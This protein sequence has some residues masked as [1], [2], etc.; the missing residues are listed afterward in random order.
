MDLNLNRLAVSA[1]AVFAALECAALTVTKV[2]EAPRINKS[3][4]KQIS[5]ITWAGDDLYYAV[6]DQNGRLYTLNLGIDLS[7]GAISATNIT[8][9]ASAK[10]EGAT[11]L[12]DCAFDKAAGSVWVVD[13]NGSKIYEVNPKTGKKNRTVKVPRNMTENYH[14]YGL[15]SLAMSSDGLAL[16]TCSEETLPCDGTISTKTA[17]STVR[18]T[19]FA[20][21]SAQDDWRLSG[22]WAY[23]TEPMGCPSMIIK[24]E[25]QTRSGISALTVLPDGSLLV[26]ERALK[27]DSIWNL[28]FYTRIYHVDFC[29]EN[30]EKATDVSGM[31]SLKDA[32]SFTYVKKTP[33]FD[34]KVGWTNYE[35][36]CIGPRLADG[37]TV[38]VLVSDGGKA[39]AC[40]VMTLKLSSE[41][42]P[43]PSL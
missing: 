40:M 31:Q 23:K 9:G 14:N 1:F 12:E 32:A 16:W 17:G 25:S 3:S 24:N 11:D 5:G 29:S 36:M 6:D 38:L 20:R 4:A 8:I 28:A 7:T 35:G 10:L 30:G 27:G 39:T 34:R 18:L 22:Q 42:N 2:S 13:E 19:R 15:E 26:L 21:K 33:L 41:A 37:S 43:Q